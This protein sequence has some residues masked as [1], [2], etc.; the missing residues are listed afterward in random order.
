M[1]ELAV[2][3]GRTIFMFIGLAAE[4]PGPVKTGVAVAVGATFGTGVAVGS[5]P[6]PIAVSNTNSPMIVAT[7]FVIGTPPR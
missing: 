5:L 7:N 1:E 3:H 4:E 2:D 6:Q